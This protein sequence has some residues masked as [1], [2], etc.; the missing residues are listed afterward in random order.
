MTIS[1]QA[2]AH[3]LFPLL[4]QRNSQSKQKMLIHEEKQA[5]L[6]REVSTTQRIQDE[7]HHLIKE[8]APKM[9]NLK[10]HGLEVIT[11]IFYK[12][13]NYYYVRT[14]FTACCHS[15]TFF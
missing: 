14:G 4:D 12:M 5:Q 15:G 8:I 10:D 1:P 3:P 11:L 7:L 13:I 6:A 2:R 9:F